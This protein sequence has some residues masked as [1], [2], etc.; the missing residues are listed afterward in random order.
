M[1]IVF[2]DKFPAENPV[3]SFSSCFAVN[4]ENMVQNC[5]ILIIKVLSCCANMSLADKQ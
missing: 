1:T 3:F 2:Y 5:N 4:I